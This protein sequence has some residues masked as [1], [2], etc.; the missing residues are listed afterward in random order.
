[1]EVFL[2]LRINR[3]QR[4]REELVE[5]FYNQLERMYMQWAR[6]RRMHLE[7]VSFKNSNPDEVLTAWSLSGFGVINLMAGEPGIHMFE[8]VEK[9]KTLRVK[10]SVHVVPQPNNAPESDAEL[11]AKLWSEE[12]Q[13]EQTDAAEITRRYKEKPSASV[14][15]KPGGWKTGQL[16]EVLAGNFDLFGEE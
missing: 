12:M 16:G 4:V 5:Q 1:M 13:K 14:V 7:Q 8:T 9:K 10:A 3:N 2:V 6:N 15:D 11:F